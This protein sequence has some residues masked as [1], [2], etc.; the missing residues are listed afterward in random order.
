MALIVTLFVVALV[1][2][3][4][5]EYHFDAT[6]EL[7]LATNYSEDI[8]AYYLAMA[9][10]NF[11]RAVLQQD[12]AASD[13][14]GDVWFRVGYVPAGSVPP[15][16]SPQQLLGL[17][18]MVG[19]NGMLSTSGIPPASTSEREEEEEAAQYDAGCVSLRIV[20]EA[21]K[22]PINALQP[23]MGTT[24]PDPTWQN[25]FVKFFEDFGMAEDTIEALVDWLDTDDE[26][27]GSGGAEN[28]YYEGLKTPYKAH[29]GP[30]F[31]PGEL[32]MV[33]G[34]TTPEI[35]ARLFPGVAEAAVA[36]LDLGD[37]EYLTPYGGETSAPQMPETPGGGTKQQQQ[38]Q[39][40]QKQQQQKQQQQEQQTAGEGKAGTGGGQGNPEAAKVN[41]NTASPAVLQILFAALAETNPKD[42]SLAVGDFEA[43]RHKKALDNEHFKTL[44]EAL[45]AL[46]GGAPNGLSNV[47]DVK[48]TYFRV[49]AAGKVGDI[50]IKA[51]DNGNKEDRNPRAVK[52][53][54]KKAIAI[55]KREGTTVKMISFK[56]E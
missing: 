36:D 51:R 2:I 15:C 27:R 6:V 54:V 49:E 22:L 55:F 21:S 13:G 26:P 29:N 3:L 44:N 10:I 31:S 56:I 41:L 32:R 25:V 23:A 37:N 24:D 53:V 9:G 39:Q 18:A 50:A 33:R 8:Q 5:L 42:M 30:M 45:N 7:D 19:E 38:K 12:E 17:G 35:V 28:S 20:D 40:Q 16:V 1:T 47:A 43:E 52:G 46:T 48:S 34:F 14:A 11:A 4:V